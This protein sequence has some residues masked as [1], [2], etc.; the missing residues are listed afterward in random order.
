MISKIKGKVID[1]SN[2]YLIIEIGGL[3]LNVFCPEET[4][5][6][7]IGKDVELHTYLSVKENSIELFG[8][9]EK[10][11]LKFFE[12]LISISGIGPKSAIGILNIAPV[13]VIKKAISSGDTTSLV[14]IS[15]IGKKTAEKISLELKEKIKEEMSS[16]DQYDI[17]GEADVIEALKALGYSQKEAR[18]VLREIDKNL[19]PQE[20]IKEALKSLNSNH[21]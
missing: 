11:S 16:D 6:E 21:E 19:S 5:Q 13:E 2:K 20:K 14:R 12:M 10:K 15:G 3:A 1:H 18:E 4:I 7:S 9:K 17:K 8:F